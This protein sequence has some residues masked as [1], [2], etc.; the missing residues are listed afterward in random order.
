MRIRPHL[1]VM[2]LSAG[3]VLTGACG[4]SSGPN[5]STVA[6]GVL[7]DVPT[8]IISAYALVNSSNLPG[9][10]TAFAADT[11][12]LNFLDAKS[13]WIID[14]LT[15]SLSEA[16]QFGPAQTLGLSAAIDTWPADTTNI[17]AILAGSATLD[18]N[19][20]AT[21]AGS[22][23]GL[24]AIEF[25]LFGVDGT[26]TTADFTARE[27]A[28]LDGAGQELLQNYSDLQL[29]WEPSFGNYVAE[30]TTAGQAGSVY[31]TRTAALQEIVNGMSNLADALAIRMS[32]AVADSTQDE[33]A[34]SDNSIND[35]QA[36][37]QSI[38]DVYLGTSNGFSYGSGVQP[39]VTSSSG[40]ADL[41]VLS[42]ITAAQNAI[43]ALGASFQDALVTN[44]TGVQT[45]ITAVGAL[46]QTL[47]TVVLPLTTVD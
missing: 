16:F 39:L 22:S 42:A 38:E 35:F 26:K 13:A 19:F 41:Q 36:N 27:L 24:H 46:Q 9:A 5:N 33:S 32:D 40:A 10:L 30:I 1:A 4:D 14:R 37:I 43:T 29:A 18:A 23:K 11:A 45:A 17:A 34:F 2:T 25:L 31:P 8:Q 44:P 21:T 3:L 28:F 20:F 47:D 15:W 12:G 6:A 7:A